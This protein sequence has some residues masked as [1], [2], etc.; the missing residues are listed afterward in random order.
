MATAKTGSF[1]L[2]HELVLANANQIYQGELS[3]GQY[4]DVGDQQALAIELID[5]IVQGYDTANDHYFNSLPGTVTANS[6]VGFQISD[7]NPNTLLLGADNHALIASGALLW[8]Q[9][10]FIQSV[11]SDFYPDDF[12][13]GGKLSESRMVVNDTLYFTGGAITT[14]AA[15]HEIRICVRIKAKIVKLQV[16]DWMSLAITGIGSDA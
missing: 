3:L 8:D 6:S 16:K 15:D 5:F 2:T 11:G 12:S 1:W 4:V 13:K 14:Y 7:L 9:T 10:N